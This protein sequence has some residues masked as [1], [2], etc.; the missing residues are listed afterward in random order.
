ME[1]MVSIPQQSHRGTLQ[2]SGEG[3]YNPYIV[4]LLQG[5]FCFWEV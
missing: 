2:Q 3:E 4:L 5:L 1:N